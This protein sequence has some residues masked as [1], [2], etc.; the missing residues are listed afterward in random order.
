MLAAAWSE[1]GQVGIWDLKPHLNAVENRST[2]RVR[3]Q[4]TKKHRREKIGES[5]LPLFTFAGH[6]QEGYAMD[7][8]STTEGSLGMLVIPK[9]VFLI[10]NIK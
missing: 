9:S 3:S 8:S 10:W 1:L 4:K 6:L 7:W 5:D 2:V